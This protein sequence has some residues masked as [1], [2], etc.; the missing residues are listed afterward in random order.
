M[1]LKVHVDVVSAEK[2]LFSGLAEMVV[3]TAELGEVGIL[4]GHSPLLAR[5]KPGQIRIQLSEQET[6]IIYVSSGLL[7]V[8]PRIVTILADYAE[9]AANLDESGVIKAQEAARRAC[10]DSWFN[11]E[12]ARTLAEATAQLQ[13]IDRLRRQTYRRGK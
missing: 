6:H 10:Q 13:A 1:A 5:L 11:V 12:C 4:P 9:D 7:E 3:A 2:E 8:Q